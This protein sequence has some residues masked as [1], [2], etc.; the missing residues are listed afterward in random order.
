MKEKVKSF[1]SEHGLTQATLSRSIGVSSA[2]ISQFLKGNY[3]GDV[4]SLEE[5]LNNFMKNYSP[6]EA[7]DKPFE[8]VHTSNMQLSHFIINEVIVSQKMMAIYGEAGSGKSTMIEEFAKT[9]PEAIVIE[10]I[11][12]MR[13]KEVL[14]EIA[15]KVGVEPTGAITT[16]IRGIS[17]KLQIREAV[18]II[19]EAE[20][21]V[22]STLEAIRRIWD[23]S[24][25]PTVLVGTYA[26]LSNLKGR[27][28]ELLQLNS[29]I[30][31]K[32]EFSTLSDEEW[33]MFFGDMAGEITRITKNLRI[34]TNLFETATRFA[35]MKNQK[36]NAG[37]IKAVLS[38]VMIDN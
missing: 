11:P 37:H 24:K 34:A 18:L 10:A 17:K 9:H 16:L 27:N 25:V 4:K 35:S 6:K 19:D 30:T 33:K 28:G 36:L 12:G 13:T 2:Q 21:L 23:F 22:T 32:V 38:T 8:V 1:L 29:R 26:L 31:R 7:L 14:Q 3:K 20:N 5:K 15:S